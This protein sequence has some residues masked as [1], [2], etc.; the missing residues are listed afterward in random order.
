MQAP[1]G[2]PSP[3]AFLQQQPTSKMMRSPPP[4]QQFA[5]PFDA[6][7]PAPVATNPFGGPAFPPPAQQTSAAASTFNVLDGG[8]QDKLFDGIILA[9]EKPV[10]PDEA[11]PA[12]SV[13]VLAAL[14]PLGTDRHFVNKQQFFKEMKPQKT[15]L[16]DLQ[17][18]VNSQHV[19]IALLSRNPFDVE[20]SS[21]SPPLPPRLSTKPKNPDNWINFDTS[22]SEVPP[23]I[24][25]PPIPPPPPN[26]SDSIP[27][28]PPPRP[29]VSAPTP[30]LPKRE[31]PTSH[32][33]NPIVAALPEPRSS[34]DAGYDS[35][36]DPLE[37]VGT[38]PS[39]TSSPPTSPPIPIPVRRPPKSTRHNHL[40]HRHHRS[41]AIVLPPPPLPVTSHSLPSSRIP[42]SSLDS[43][44]SQSPTRRRNTS[45]GSPTESCHSTPEP[46]RK[47]SSDDS[48][49][50]EKQP[51]S[52]S[53]SA[54]PPSAP[55]DRYAA[56]ESL[57]R[58]ETRGDFSSIF[59]KYLPKADE[60][61][62]DQFAITLSDDK[63]E[64][65]NPKDGDR[66]IAHSFSD[67]FVPES[68]LEC[69]DKPPESADNFATPIDVETDDAFDIFPTSF[70]AET[71][72]SADVFSSASI[73]KDSDVS[74]NVFSSESAEGDKFD[75]FTTS[76]TIERS[77]DSFASSKDF[78]ESTKKLGL[79]TDDVKTSSS[80]VIENGTVTVL[81]PV[82]YL[83][84]KDIFHRDGDPFDDD[85][86]QS[87][88]AASSATDSRFKDWTTNKWA[89]KS[90]DD[91]KFDNDED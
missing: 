16:R 64:S 25:P 55:D 21:S 65:P 9:P 5:N 24:P 13:D 8:S 14:D 78:P 38:S 75:V 42:S 89:L 87:T 59:D 49:A 7:I 18:G 33:P 41:P 85:F 81:S 88:S 80:A 86:F 72:I 11:Q 30:P 1:I 53:T 73:G 26:P 50:N 32:S 46:I 62:N 56:I 10:T 45:E 67:F 79:E 90:F 82:S 44:L 28:T 15:A 36:D 63:F 20:S 48:G 3:T 74:T 12:G 4:S 84:S 68:P 27:P 61:D 43:A 17:S 47:Q 23:P 76:Q 19:S 51:T 69:E 70:N 37:T 77:D 40:V 60:D 35:Y 71:D 39:S 57:E 52:P 22:P 6:P 91:F 54:A 34:S 2:G 83:N 58:G 29:P 31:R 66:R